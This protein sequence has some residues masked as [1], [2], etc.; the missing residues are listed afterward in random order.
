[1][2]GEK[3]KHRPFEASINEVKKMHDRNMLKDTFFEDVTVVAWH[4]MDRHAK[5]KDSDGRVFIAN[6]RNLRK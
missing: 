5:V 3:M 6:K 2:V 1:M 4:L